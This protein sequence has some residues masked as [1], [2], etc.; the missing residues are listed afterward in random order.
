MPTPSNVTYFATPADLR[1]WFRANAAKADELWVGYYKKDSGRPS[2]TWP[3]SV[4]EALCVGWIDGIRKT[5]DAE[6]YT[7][8]FTPRRK[9]SIWSK[10][11]VARMTDLAAQKRVRPAGAKAFAARLEN[12]TGIYSYE[13]RPDDLPE[14]YAGTLKKNKTAWT[15][16]QGLSPYRRKT[17]VWWIVS[18]KQEPTRQD[19]LK[20]LIAS[21]VQGRMPQ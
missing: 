1:K 21:C 17:L 7:I 15:F 3:E 8:R 14:P 5:I 9:T 10:V 4:D 2:I 6:R 20:K 19:R 16:Y 11:N 13:N 12:K 18:A